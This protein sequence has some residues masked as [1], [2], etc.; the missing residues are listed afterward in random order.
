MGKE[1][2]L[3]KQKKS[4]LQ[5]EIQTLQK[6]KNSRQ[7]QTEIQKESPL[8]KQKKNQIQTEIQKKSPLQTEIQKRPQMGLQMGLQVRHQ[9][10]VLRRLEIQMGLQ[11]HCLRQMAVQ[12]HL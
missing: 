12:E 1:N 10:S 8:Q 9:G 4:Q 6:E 11:N 3:Q 7:I 2:P 5:T